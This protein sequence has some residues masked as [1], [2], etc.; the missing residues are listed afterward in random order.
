MPY[1]LLLLIQPLDRGV[2]GGHG[3]AAVEPA[4]EAHAHARGHAKEGLAVQDPTL[5]LKTAIRS[6][7]QVSM[8]TVGVI[9]QF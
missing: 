6:P 8:T 5:T 1:C 9:I 2:A 3:P 4:T 7:V